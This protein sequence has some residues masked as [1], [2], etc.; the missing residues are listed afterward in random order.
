MKKDKNSFME[1]DIFSKT[2]EL[3]LPPVIDAASV[4]VLMFLGEQL[5]IKEPGI[6]YTDF[7]MSCLKRW[8][9]ETSEDTVWY[10][11]DHIIEFKIQDLIPVLYFK[12]KEATNFIFPLI[13]Y[14]DIIFKKLKVYLFPQRVENGIRI[15]IIASED[16]PK[17]QL[18]KFFYELTA[19]DESLAKVCFV[20]GSNALK[21]SKWDKAIRAFEF[22]LKITPDDI[23]ARYLLGATY[24]DKGIFYQQNN[25]F[26]EALE[27]YEKALTIWENI[28]KVA[29]EFLLDRINKARA[30]VYYNK[31]LCYSSLRQ[32]EEELESY[33]L[34]LEIDPQDANA[35]NNKG[36]VLL[37]LGKYEEALKAFEKVL[38]LEPD[39][40]KDW[41]L[42]GICLSYLGRYS[43]AIEAYD[44]AL[45][46]N[47]MSDYVVWYNKGI[48]LCALGMCNESLEAF[49]KA[50][51]LNPEHWASWLM[52]GIILYELGDKKEAVQSFD[53]VIQ[54]YSPNYGVEGLFENRI[55]NCKLK[56][57]KKAI[58]MYNIQR[59]KHLKQKGEE[60]KSNK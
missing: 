37:Q 26:K 5:K 50:L 16:L 49:N 57:Y 48:D 4:L 22:G 9:T 47:P 24:E 56:H 23:S 1:G 30:R 36:F 31:G 6:K 43:E 2:G 18:S 45:A 14:E 54:L 39:D 15:A 13:E 53:K 3:K 51:E 40:D 58:E 41:Y 8:H 35:W 10:I 44:Q 27:M 52:R 11:D 55:T 32:N 38:A 59:A 33:N 42:K 20:I 17:V 34:A 12:G 60:I 7:C 28:I 21:E 25:K 19:P 29:P 46:I